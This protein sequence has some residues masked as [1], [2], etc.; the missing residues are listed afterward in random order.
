VI[1]VVLVLFGNGK[2]LGRNVYE[3]HVPGASS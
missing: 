2:I 1:L 3:V